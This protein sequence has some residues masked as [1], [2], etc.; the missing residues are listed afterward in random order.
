[1]AL[2]KLDESDYLQKE[3][4]KDYYSELTFIIRKYLDEKVY[5]R[6]LESTTDELVERLNMLR[7]ASQIELSN[8]DI[9]NIEVILKRADLVKFAKS[10]PDI[11]LA[12][13]DRNT[14]DVEIDQVKESLPEPTEEEKLLDEQYRVKQQHKSKRK[15]MWLT[16]AASILIL[17]ATFIGFGVKYG[18]KYVVDTVIGE[19]SKVLLEGQWVRSDYGVPPI[20]IST[21]VVL[22]R[23]DLQ[24][25]DTLQQVEMTMFSYGDLNSALNI[26]VSTSKYKDLGKNADG[27]PNTIDLNLAV[28][29]NIKTYENNGARNIILKKEQFIT[30]NAAEGLKAFGTAQFPTDK[31]GEYKEGEYVILAFTGENVLQQIV[32]VWDNQNEY[33]NQTIDRIIESIE[34]KKLEE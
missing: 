28:E 23:M 26:L 6:A 19:E 17:L 11:E 14:I 33:T 24:A 10:E 12:K 13:L 3:E 20:M 18:F 25:I 30:P 15:K 29:G 21:P 9:K 1:M 27:E 7:E 5:D 2:K 22:E 8:D 4:L 34:L 16:V 31:E 32:L